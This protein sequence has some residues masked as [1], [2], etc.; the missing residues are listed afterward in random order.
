VRNPK[1]PGVVEM[2][3][4][5]AEVWVNELRLTDFNKKGGWAATATIQAQ[6]ADFGQVTVAGMRTS[7]GFASLDSKISD[8]NLESLT[9]FD[10]ST[11]LQLGKF[12]PEK[13]GIRIPMHFDY[14]ETHITPEYNPIDPDILLQEDL[15]SYVAKDKQDSVKRL[16]VDYTQRKNINFMNVRKDRVGAK[17]PRIYDLENFNVTYAYSE[18]YNRNVDIEYDLL[19]QNRGGFGYNFALAPKNVRPFEKIGFIS[20]TKALQIIKDFN[21]YYL[22][23]SFSFNTEMNRSYGEMKLR[24]KSLGVIKIRPS[25]N[26]SWIW[27]R[28]Y[29]LKFDLA[30]SL[31]LQYNATANTFINEAPGSKHKNSEWYNEAAQDTISIKNQIFSFGNM[32]RYV[33]NLSVNYV[34]PIDKLP[35]LDWTTATFVYQSSYSWTASPLSIQQRMGNQIENSRTIQLNGNLAFD[36]LYNKSPYLKELLRKN[37]RR[38]RGGGTPPGNR[39][40]RG[41]QAQQNQAESDTTEKVRPNYFKIIGE[42]MLKIILGIKKTTIS[43]SQSTGTGLPGFMPEPDILGTNLSQRA[44]GIGFAFGSQKDIRQQAAENGW[45]TQDSN[46]NQP[47]LTKYQNALV[48]RTTIEP[49]PDF[50]VEITA[51]RNYSENHQEYY[52]WSDSLSSFNSFSPTDAGS[53]SISYIAWKTAFEKEEGDNISPTFEEMKALRPGIAEELARENPNW[54]G[55]YVYDSITGDYYPEGY[56]PTSPE[57]LRPAFLQAYSGKSK[58]SQK[59]YFPSFPLPNW[60]ITY[61]GLSKIKF[62]A[63]VI[64]KLT[65]SHAYSSTYS[66]NSFR[67]NL[68]Y[69]ETNGYASG[70]QQFSTDY[71]SRYDLGQISITEQFS[72]LFGIDMTWHN[73]LFTKVEYKKARNLTMSF[74]NNQVTEVKSNELVVGVGYRIKSLGFTIKALGGGGRKTRVES[75]LDIKVDF[76][77]RSNKT[78]LR[79]IDEDINQVSAGQKIVSINT[80]IDYQLNQNLSIR[81]FFDKIVNNPFVSNQ[82]KNSTTNGGISLRFSLSQ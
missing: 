1:K 65:L 34:I 36:K 17:K 13:A 24:D 68:G 32:N 69:L 3:P 55:Q 82:Y 7:A 51:D 53:F 19:Q 40:S 37:D 29:D 41:Q 12:F 45:I 81:L 10:V 64:Q 50:N 8:V 30:K 59:D 21:F 27:D 57:V 47:Y 46:L 76:S 4:I 54:N 26:K 73:S 52:R 66:V 44:P 78:V 33:Q 22:P 35:L 70:K 67:T 49:L 31:T 61:T 6:L 72:P 77:I 15:D 63:K 62:I 18:I 71:I 43:Y 60:R 23:K 75:D 11:D 2:Q 56:G 42:G 5:C 74:T 58:K 28:N 80:S 79:R 9:Q 14:S 38:Q 39:E 48:F 16:V 25:Y 20:K